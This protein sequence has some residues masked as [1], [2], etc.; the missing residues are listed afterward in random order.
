MAPP[1]TEQLFLQ[2]PEYRVIVGRKCQHAIQPTKIVTHLRHPNHRIPTLDAQYIQYTVSTWQGFVQEPQG[3]IFPHSVIYPIP[4]LAVYTDGLSCTVLENCD[5]VCRSIDSIRKH[6]KVEH[7]LGLNPHGRPPQCE[8][9]ILH[10]LQAE[11]M[12]RVTYQRLFL[13]RKGSYYIYVRQPP[14]NQ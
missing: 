12:Q 5:Y 2:L 14:D 9:P 10:E 7:N 4:G 3:L 13:S 1:T 11:C 8:L 6:I